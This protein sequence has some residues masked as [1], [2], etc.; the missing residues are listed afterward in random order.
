MTPRTAHYAVYG[1]ELPKSSCSRSVGILASAGQNLFSTVFNASLNVLP[2]DGNVSLFRTSRLDPFPLDIFV[3][4]NGRTVKHTFKTVGRK[5]VILTQTVISTGRTYHLHAFVM[6]KV[7]TSCTTTSSIT[8]F[9]LF[10]LLRV[11]PGLGGVVRFGLV[12]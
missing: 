12:A 9:L 2:I 6:V 1:T 7:R 5:Q 11:Y 8:L 3:D 10:L 4:T